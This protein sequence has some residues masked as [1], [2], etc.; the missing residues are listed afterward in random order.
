[1]QLAYALALIIS[2]PLQLLPAF[3]SMEEFAIFSRFINPKIKYSRFRRLLLRLVVNVTMGFV[4][5]GIPSFAYFINILG[6]CM[7]LLRSGSIGGATTMCLIPVLVHYSMFR[8]DDARRKRPAVY[9]GLF[10][11]GLVGGISSF[12]YSVVKLAEG[13]QS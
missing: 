12:I 9:V 7:F 10:S 13:I 11:Y 3:H 8:S 5:Y 6:T 1:M 4:G 2:Y